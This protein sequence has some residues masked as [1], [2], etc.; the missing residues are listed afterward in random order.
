MKP[1]ILP[2]HY[3]YIEAYLT[4]DC[5]MACT[6]CLNHFLPLTCPVPLTT[7]LW[8]KALGRLNPTRDLPITLGGGEPTMH[9]GFYKIVD[10]IPDGRVDLL[11]NGAFVCQEF[12]E[13]VSPKKFSRGARYASIR[14]SL[15][16]TTDLK[17][18]YNNL[19]ILRSNGYSVGL[20][21]TDHPTMTRTLLHARDFC[22][23]YQIDFRV[24]EFLGYYK[25]KLYG[26]Y[27][28]PDA[29]GRGYT[30]TVK[31]NPSELLIAS[32]G[33]V[34]KC[35]A[36]LYAYRN[37]IGDMSKTVTFSKFMECSEYGNCHPCDIKLK[38]NRFQEYGHCSVEVKKSL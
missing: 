18:L 12:M 29:I 30:S 1:I 8:I 19:T 28:Y 17:L 7:D 6:Y 3:N 13:N 5:N 21:S 16:P 25:G 38:Y 33:V 10:S 14:I 20:W 31:C 15:H 27:K 24:K 35:H 22:V 36:D 4:Y 37:P 26:R 23:D 11:T 2:K 9:P 34:F 32:N